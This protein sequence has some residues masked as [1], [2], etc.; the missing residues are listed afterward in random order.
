MTCFVPPSVYTLHIAVEAAE[1]GQELGFVKVP[2]AVLHVR[3]D[4]RPL[5]EPPVCVVLRAIKRL[6][7][8]RIV[9]QPSLGL[10]RLLVSLLACQ[11]DDLQELLPQRFIIF[12]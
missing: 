9:L 7:K 4:A 11:K 5:V 8:H 6:T 2:L 10:V 12:L 3:L 1:F